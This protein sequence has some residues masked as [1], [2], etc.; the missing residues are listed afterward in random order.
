LLATADPF[1]KERVHLR[2]TYLAEYNSTAT[3]SQNHGRPVSTF[4]MKSTNASLEC[5]FAILGAYFSTLEPLCECIFIS[6]E[7]EK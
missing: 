6:N 1:S 5:E 3:R 7:N 2:V 4:G